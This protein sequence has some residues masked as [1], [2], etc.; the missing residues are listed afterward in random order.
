LLEVL[1]LPCERRLTDVEALRGPTHVAF[2]GD[3]DE[4]LKLDETHDQN[5][6]TRR[7]ER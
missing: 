3:C 6:I 7:P 1:D 5:S 4:V 2:L